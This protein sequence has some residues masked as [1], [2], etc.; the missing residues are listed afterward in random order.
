MALSDL[1]MMA[2]ATALGVGSVIL[3]ATSG[4]IWRISIQ[5]PESTVLL[6]DAALSLAFFLQ[7]SGMV[8]RRF[9][10]RL[11]PV[12]PDRY[13]GA[14][15]TI[16]SGLVLALVAL[17]WQRSGIYLLQLQGLPLW[18]ARSC[19]ALALAFFVWGAI[20]LRPFDPL[21]LA[22]IRAH[23]QGKPYQSV[24][25]IVRGPYR[26]VRH[27]LYSSILLLFWSTPELTADRLL[28]NLLWTGWIIAGTVLEEKDLTAQF[29]DAY[30]NYQQ[31][32]PMLIPWRGRV[33]MAD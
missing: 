6:W 13:Q 23:L 19:T 21:G 4:A 10:A 28:F 3:F 9:R 5:W 26:W 18:I 17:L 12:I 8:R 2:L 29:G 15:Y 30:R 20:A 24:P 7:H 33:A 22:P 14:F 25:F 11:A 1:A 31:K 27:P 16:A 32:V